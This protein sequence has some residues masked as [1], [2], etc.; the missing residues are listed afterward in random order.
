[1]N[2][3][4][5]SKEK[6]LIVAIEECGEL[7]QALTKVLREKGNYHNTC[8]EIADVIIC[9]NWI[10]EKLNLDV[11]DIMEW[12]NKKLERTKKRLEEGSF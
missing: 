8:E 9:I 6:V 10:I 7:I 12:Q 1:M 2:I 3:E 5:L 11:N 4:S